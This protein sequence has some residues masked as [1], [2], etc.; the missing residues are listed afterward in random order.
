L[1]DRGHDTRSITLKATAVLRAVP[2]ALSF[3]ASAGAARA[4]TPVALVEDVSGR[5][6]GIEFMDYVVPGQVIALGPRDAIVLGYIRSCWRESVR[7]GTIKIGQD[8]SEVSGGTVER[9]KVACDGG[10]MEL[11]AAQARQGATSVMRVPDARARR[12]SLPKPQ[13]VL[14]GRSPVVELKGGGA[15]AIE[16]LDA[17]GEKFAIDLPRARLVRDT[18][19]DLA[20]S[21]IT[22][23]P[24]GLYMARVGE[25]QIVFQVAG[26]APSGKAPLAGRLLRFRPPG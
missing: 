18:F 7:G 5:P 23:S 25:Q 9:V 2:L 13:F 1:R 12:S 19:A 3:L 8:Q 4:E 26:D 11:A 10:R 6:P 20:D 22:L 24:G 14:H 17:A 15:I 16:R 21:G